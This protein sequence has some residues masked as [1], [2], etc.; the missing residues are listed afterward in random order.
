MVVSMINQAKTQYCNETL[1]AA[2]AKDMFQIVAN[3]LKEKYFPV[4]TPILP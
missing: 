3:H 4:E 2:N 1:A